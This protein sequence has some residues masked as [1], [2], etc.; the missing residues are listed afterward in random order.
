MTESERLSL[1]KQ[2]GYWVAAV[3]KLDKPV[4][5][6]VKVL[7]A[8]TVWNRL[9]LLIAPTDGVNNIWVSAGSVRDLHYARPPSISIPLAHGGGVLVRPFA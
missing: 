2:T 9:D 5:V 6:R 4:L 1:I 7:D 8:R 3:N